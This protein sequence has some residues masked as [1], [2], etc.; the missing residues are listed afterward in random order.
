MTP[1]EPA[2][3]GV[4]AGRP[5]R[6]SARARYLAEL[7]LLATMLVW[8]GNFVVVKAALGAMG[9]LTFAALRF[10]VAATALFVFVRLRQGAIRWPTG[11]GLTLLLLGMVGFGV[12]NLLWTN[13]LQ[14]VTAGNSALLIAT[15]PVL[16]ALLAGAVG[17]D[18]LTRPKLVGA[19]LAF[20]GVAVVILGG[21]EAAI[22][23]SPL[24]FAF[25]LGSAA[26]WAIYATAG[27]RMLR[28]VDP[29]QASAW[30]VLGGAL[31][32]L[33]FG[34]WEVATHPA[35]TVTPAVIG[36]AVYSGAL[37]AG[38]ANFAVLHAIRLLGPTRVTAFQFLPPAG[39]VVL[40]AILLGEPVGAYQV[41]GGAVIVLGVWLTRR[42]RVVPASLGIRLRV[43]R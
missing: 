35:M 10:A 36:A 27:A 22:G 5:D 33:P 17:L 23:G 1:A 16:T 41:L 34:A 28:H 9:P 6:A 37:A 15:S 24:G 3:V 40:G 20:G 38:I 2:G 30:L 4:S 12:Y 32:L 11:H 26:I 19:L 39:A 13:G 31:F 21:R 14:L 25:T 8:S 7:G 42:T 29:G 18:R 43:A